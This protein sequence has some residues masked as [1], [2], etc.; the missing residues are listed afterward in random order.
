MALNGDLIFS[1]ITDIELA[2]RLGID[3]L[4]T[5]I[6]GKSTVTYT[7]TVTSGTELGK[8]KIDN[9]TKKIYAPESVATVNVTQTVTT[10]TELATITVDDT[11]TKIYAP[12]LPEEKHLEW[13]TVATGT[14]NTTNGSQFAELY[15][16]FSSLS[17]GEKVLT[18]LKLSNLLYDLVDIR[19]VFAHNRT[20]S[21]SFRSY[22]AGIITDSE[23]Y[24]WAV[25]TADGITF[26]DNIAETESMSWEL[27]VL[28]L[29]A[30]T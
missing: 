2:D 1:P 27:Q 10:G 4:E 5:E 29:V 11:S 17:D 14:A 16:V 3:E 26:E 9:T 8:I 7:P 12:T 6:A 13:V 25:N 28:S 23:Y 19:G 30:N 21:T 20:L 22:C 18:R 15:T 24:I